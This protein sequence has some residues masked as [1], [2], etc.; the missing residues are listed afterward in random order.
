MEQAFIQESRRYLCR[1]YPAKIRAA[2]RHL[3]EEEL[4]RQPNSTSNSVGRLILHLC[5]NVRQWVVHGLGREPDTRDRA[6]EFAATGGPTARELLAQM[7]TTLAE[8]DRTLAGLAPGR[9]EETVEVQGIRTSG[10]AALFHAVEHFSMHTGQIL[11]IVKARSGTDLGFY[12][13]DASGR[14][15]NTTW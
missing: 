4:W 10:L 6:R 2:L 3:P 12:E 11:Y 9:L 15:T 8:V 14:V 5:G 7:D 1:E 13:I